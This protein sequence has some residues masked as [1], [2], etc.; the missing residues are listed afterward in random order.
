MGFVRASQP[1][2]MGFSGSHTPIEGRGNP[3]I[4]MSGLGDASR[5][6]RAPRHRDSRR[7][8]ASYLYVTLAL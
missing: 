2:T 5:T 4:G 8:A 1:P 6:N 7:P 3:G